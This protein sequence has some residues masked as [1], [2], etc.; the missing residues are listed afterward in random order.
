MISFGRLTAYNHTNY[1]FIQITVAIVLIVSVTN[2]VVILTVH[3][4]I[5]KQNNPV[6]ATT[7]G[8][9]GW[10]H[11]TAIRLE[12]HKDG[13]ELSKLFNRGKMAAPMR[14]TSNI[15]AGS[16]MAVPI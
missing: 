9:N 4:C 15:Y 12:Y 1:N 2:K 3:Q 7:V 5:C 11:S 16:E 8:G 13:N 14:R 6:I 10:F